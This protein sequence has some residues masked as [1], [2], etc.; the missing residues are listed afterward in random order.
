VRRPETLKKKAE[1]EI[2][3]TRVG[4]VKLMWRSIFDASRDAGGDNF[5]FN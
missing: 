5:S 4:L 3:T 1:G 2:G